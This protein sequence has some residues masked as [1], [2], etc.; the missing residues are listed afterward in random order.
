MPDD[1]SVTKVVIAGLAVA[2]AIAVSVIVAFWLYRGSHDGPITSP[3]IAGG[4]TLQ[5][6]PGR[7]VAAYRAEK[8]R[9]L[10][11]YA[12]VDRDR[13]IV[14]IPIERA[15]ALRARQWRAAP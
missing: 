9:T 1:V 7:D 4:I 13:G 3:V 2:A 10:S 14:T 11:R 5:S 15:M 6:A 12:W 8:Q